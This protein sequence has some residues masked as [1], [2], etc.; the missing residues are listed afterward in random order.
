MYFAER[1]RPQ[2]GLVLRVV[3]DARR[4]DE[5]FVRHDPH[6][7]RASSRSA[8]LRVRSKSAPGSALTAASTALSASGR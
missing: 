4:S 5:T 1:P 8:C 3:V 6:P 2:P 7:Y